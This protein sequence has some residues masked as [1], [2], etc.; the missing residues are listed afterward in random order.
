M[1][2]HRLLD[3]LVEGARDLAVLGEFK[4]L[5]ELQRHFFDIEINA[6]GVGVGNQVVFAGMELP[7]LLHLLLLVLQPLDFLLDV[8]EQVL[9][10]V[11]V[12]LGELDF[13]P[14][15]LPPDYH[16]SEAEVAHFSQS[17]DVLLVADVTLQ[18]GGMRIWHSAELVLVFGR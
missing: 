2:V 7:L 4:H 6:S 5:A 1:A 8:G 10:R 9:A 12:G 3:Y 17:F 14:C 15:L 13:L 18:L 16:A 11:V